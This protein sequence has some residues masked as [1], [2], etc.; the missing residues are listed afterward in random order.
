MVKVFGELC[1]V[2]KETIGDRYR[3][4]SWNRNDRSKYRKYQLTSLKCPGAKQAHPIHSGVLSEHIRFI[5][6]HVQNS[7]KGV[8]IDKRT[9]K[10]I[11]IK[12]NFMS[13]E[14]RYIGTTADRV[15]AKEFNIF[16]GISLGNKFFTKDNIARYIN[17]ALEHTKEDVVVLIADK[18]KAINYEAM[19]NYSTS[20]ALAV[21]TRKGIEIAQTINEII[22]GLSEEQQKKVHVITWEEVVKSAWYQENLKAI[23]EEVKTN[24]SFYDYIVSIVEE[25]LPSKFSMLNK[26]G[27]EKAAEYVMNELPI[28]INGVEFNGKIYDLIPYPGLGKID[29]LAIGLQE[30]TMFPELAQKFNLGRKVAIIDL[31]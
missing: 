1:R 28:F 8:L 25:N 5:Y 18:I 16:I 31:P 7:G 11:Y 13:N 14:V 29:E 22:G 9:V 30:K 27:L 20:R 17:W 6:R 23:K 10:M 26:S 12:S 15:N 21:A 2:D 19:N 24:P 4:N 3:V